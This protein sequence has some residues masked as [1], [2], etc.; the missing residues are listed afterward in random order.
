MRVREELRAMSRFERGAVSG[1][2][3]AAL[4][5]VAVLAGGPGLEVRLLSVVVVLLTVG[6]VLQV[7]VASRWRR[8]YE[9]ERDRPR[10]ACWPA[11]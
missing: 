6:A 1:L 2:A 7:V 5:G 4:S 9:R 3:A 11:N 8:M 10:R